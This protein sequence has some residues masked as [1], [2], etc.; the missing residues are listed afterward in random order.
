MNSTYAVEYGP[1]STY[2]TEDLSIIG[3][4][5]TVGIYAFTGCAGQLSTTPSVSACP[6][7][8]L[9]DAYQVTFNDGGYG[10]WTALPAGNLAGEDT[11]TTEPASLLLIG[12]GLIGLG[13]RRFHKR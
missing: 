12:S 11:T 13:V 10:G 2:L 8:D 6:V 5:L 9:T 7:E 1:L 4:P 3:A